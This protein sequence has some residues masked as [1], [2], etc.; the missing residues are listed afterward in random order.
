[1][2][3]VLETPIQRRECLLRVLTLNPHNEA[4]RR[5]LASLNAQMA[6]PE[7]PPPPPPPKV[8]RLAP[9]RGETIACPF[10][11]Q[12]TDNTLLD[13]ESCGENVILS[14]PTCDKPIYLWETTRC[15]CGEGLRHYIFFPDG[16]DHEGLGQR[17]AMADR[18]EAAARQWD[19]ALREGAHISMLHRKLAQAYDYIGKSSEAQFHRDAATTR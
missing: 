16:I 18:W 12:Q 2:S 6:A 13:C 4:A 8:Q 17:Y 9:S 1:M 19:R 14:C 7:P 10:C 11:Q 5:G 3:S 15:P